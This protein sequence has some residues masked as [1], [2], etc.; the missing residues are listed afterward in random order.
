M[1]LAKEELISPECPWE[2]GA[3]PPLQIIHATGASPCN[4]ESH[5]GRP[6][7]YWVTDTRK[8]GQPFTRQMQTRIF[9][10]FREESFVIQKSLKNQGMRPLYSLLIVL[11]IYS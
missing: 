8:R 6:E 3:K 5:K 4:P 1:T 10:C 7:N 11:L 2:Y 9:I